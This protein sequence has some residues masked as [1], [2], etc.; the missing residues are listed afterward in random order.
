LK[1]RDITPTMRAFLGT[2]EVLRQMG[3]AAEDLY[4]QVEYSVRHPGS[5]NGFCVLR[6]QGLEFSVELGPVSSREAFAKEYTRMI[7]AVNTGALSERDLKRM[8]RESEAF[9]GRMN[10][11]AA[12]I[13][14]GI[15]PPGPTAEERGETVH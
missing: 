5:L 15:R 4:C 1:Y 13:A 11:L 12:I 14:K 8:T 10:L 2:R 7:D 3:F 6:T 9:R